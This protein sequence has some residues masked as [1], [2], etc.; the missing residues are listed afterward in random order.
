MEIPFGMWSQVD[1]RNYVL[2]VVHSPLLLLSSV[3][4][5]FQKCPFPGGAFLKGIS[6]TAEHYSQWPWC[7]DFP[8][9]IPIGRPQK[10]L[11]VTLNFSLEKSSCDMASRQNCLT[12]YYYFRYF[13]YFC[14][15]VQCLSGPC[16]ESLLLQT[17]RAVGH[18]RNSHSPNHT[19]R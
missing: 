8:T 13:C 18:C 4:N 3:R 2:D 10:Q 6:H 9:C 15:Q 12:A 7:Q 1:P 11:G 14:V 16:A 19:S 5:P 17:L